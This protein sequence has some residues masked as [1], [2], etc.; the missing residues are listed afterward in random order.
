ML[1]AYHPACHSLCSE[2]FRYQIKRSIQA[3]ALRSLLFPSIEK[4]HLRGIDPFQ[5]VRL[6]ACEPNL[7][8][9]IDALQ[10]RDRRSRNHSRIVGG[11]FEREAPRDQRIVAATE[12][13]RDLELQGDRFRT[14]VIATQPPPD[15]LAMRNQRALQLQRIEREV[16][17]EGI[18]FAVRF[19]LP[20]AD[21]MPRIASVRELI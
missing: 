1:R 12:R 15:R 11:S 2:A 8:P 19:A 6:H 16:V 14:D 18:F 3:V 9:R 4:P 5:I 21:D 7:F 20:I 17:L 13:P 10:Q